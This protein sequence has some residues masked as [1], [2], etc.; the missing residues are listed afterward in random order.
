MM[1]MKTINRT[2]HTVNTGTP[3]PKLIRWL[4]C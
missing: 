1:V 4:N 3:E 2:N